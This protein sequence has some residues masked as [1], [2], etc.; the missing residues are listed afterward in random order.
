L[1]PGKRACTDA[2]RFAPDPV[3]LYHGDMLTCP[4]CDAP[5]EEQE[6]GYWRCAAHGSFFPPG[7]LMPV[8]QRI[9]ETLAPED[10]TPYR[11]FFSLKPDV[12]RQAVARAKEHAESPRNLPCPRCRLP[13]RTLRYHG[14][15][16][17]FVDRYSICEGIFLD[18]GEE[19]TMAAIFQAYES[20][21]EETRTFARGVDPGDVE[22]RAIWEQVQLSL[23]ALA[24][25]LMWINPG[26]AVA[27]T[28]MGMVEDLLD[29]GVFV[30]LRRNRRSPSR[31]HP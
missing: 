25:L 13:M 22:A 2:P 29:T 8:I 27:S 5:M 26:I 10:Y 14:T 18:P 3:F 6:E 31:D 17:L 19:R 15:T 24:S 7:T 11:P 28:L 30:H 16:D 9:A 23:E 21:R 4:L 20:V 1:W 12:R